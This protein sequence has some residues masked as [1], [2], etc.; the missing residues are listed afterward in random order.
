MVVRKESKSGRL[1]VTDWDFGFTAVTEDEIRD[2]I[3]LPP[4]GKAQA[5]ADV[6]LPLLH[7]LMKDADRTEFIKWPNRGPVIQEQIDKINRILN[8]D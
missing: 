6:V 1:A 8:G 5:I 7:N 3:R 4:D 2:E